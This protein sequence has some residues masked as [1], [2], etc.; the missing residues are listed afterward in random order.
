MTDALMHQVSAIPPVTEWRGKGPQLIAER[1]VFTV[2]W[3]A[4][5]QVQFEFDMLRVD[6]RTGTMTAEVT[7]WTYWPVLDFVH[8]ASLNLSS[9]QARTT[10]AK[11]L[12]GRV[13]DRELD[14][15]MLV[16]Q[17]V[18]RTRNAFRAGEPSILLRDAPEPATAG[19]L[20]P[21]IVAADGATLLYGDGGT[22]K[23]LLGL[24]L[25]VSLHTGRG[26]VLGLEPAVTRRVA[27][28]DWEWSAPVHKRRLRRLLPDGE[29]PDLRY[30]RCA[31]PLRDEVDRLRRAIREHGIEYVVI[32]SV[33]LAAGGDP[34]RAETAIEFFGALRQLEVDALAIAHVTKTTDGDKPFGST[35][36]H[37]SA[38]ATWYV[39]KVQELGASS[40]RVALVNKKANDAPLSLPIGF[41]VEMSAERTTIRPT[42]LAD[43]PELAKEIPLRLRIRQAVIGGS[44]TYAELA[45]RLEADV[46]SV[47]RTVTRHVGKTFTT[48]PDGGAMRVGVLA[49]D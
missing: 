38:R 24:A 33:A 15:P 2:R 3:D 18:I 29:L 39:R 13:R 40:F 35:F 48:F 42:N 25:G 41:E 47:R 6:R 30:I 45:E 31:L 11:H 49:H 34:E 1:G 8:S 16:E 9:T 20:I 4:P 26:D 12:A 32:D 23:S 28:L 37:N 19:A 5:E 22:A 14:W 44:L 7:V 27:F 21:P 43:T 17:A 36:W 46:D 10:L